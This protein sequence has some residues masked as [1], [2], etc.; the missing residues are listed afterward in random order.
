M[1]WAGSLW[2]KRAGRASLW[3]RS[4][5]NHE[6]M[7]LDLWDWRTLRWWQCS[8]ELYN[9]MGDRRQKLNDLRWSVLKI[10]DH[11]TDWAGSII[12]YWIDIQI[13]LGWNI[14]MLILLTRYNQFIMA[15]L[16]WNSYRNNIIRI[17]CSLWREAPRQLQQ[18]DE[19]FI[20][21]WPV[22]MDNNGQF[23]ILQ[24]IHTNCSQTNKYSYIS[25]WMKCYS[26]LGSLELV[27][28]LFSS[29]VITST[30]YLIAMESVSK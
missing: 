1:H 18:F 12:M 23:G 5:Q 8:E 28:S 14:I 10:Y 20:I 30:W 29:S 11:A 15:G 9:E 16:Y 6:L 7:R 25:V 13:S 17:A 3:S 19:R 22:F 4:E 2:H 24:D 27:F 26:A 21:L